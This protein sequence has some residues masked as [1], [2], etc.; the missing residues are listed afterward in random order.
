MSS[1]VKR[2]SRG[3]SGLMALVLLALAAPAG[4]VRDGDP[5]DMDG[6][7][8]IGLTRFVEPQ[9]GIGQLT[10]ITYSSWGCSHLGK[11][12]KTSLR[13]LIDGRGDRGFDLVGNFVCRSKRLLFELRSTDGRNRYE[14]LPVHRRGDSRT[15]LVRFP[16]DLMELKRGDYTFLA[17]SRDE[18]GVTCRGDC[19]DRAPNRGRLR[20]PE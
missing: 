11:D 18:S 16:L 3:V 2:L 19:A 15:A 4:A 14:S 1:M 20:Y 12:D 9:E 10:I 8:D 5:Q 17:R 6:K 7:L 13:W